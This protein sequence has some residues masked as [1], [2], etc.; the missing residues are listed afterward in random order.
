CVEAAETIGAE[1]DHLASVVSSAVNVSSHDDI[2]TL[3][4][5]VATA[6]REV[7]TLKARALKEVW[8]I[9]AVTPLEEGRGG[10]G[11]CGKGTTNTNYNKYNNT[12]TSDSR[13]ILNGENFLGV[14]SQELLAKG[15]DLLKRTCK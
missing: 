12:N 13:E 8:N 10:I 2:T 7:A 6:L 5:T 9:A 15:S 11:I 3:F 4:A 1:K 14:G